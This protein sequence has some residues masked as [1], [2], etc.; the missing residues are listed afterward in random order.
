MMKKQEIKTRSRELFKISMPMVVEHLAIAAMGM[1]STMLVA[2]IGPHATTALGMVDSISN[3]IIAL[4]AALTTGGTI[5]VAQFIGKQ[6]ILSAKR[7]AGQAILLSVAFSVVVLAV[8]LVFHNQ[9]MYLLFGDADADV[10]AAALTFLFIVSFSFPVLAV[11]QT[12]FGIL[13]GSGDT[14]TPMII[15]ILMNAANLGL[16]I[17]LIHGLNLGIFTI[18]AFGVP[19]AA[20][21]LLIA[22]VMGLA[23]A[24]FFIVKK[25]RGVRLNKP[26]FFKPDMP[27]QKTILNLGMPTSFESALF[28]VGRLITQVF[29]VQIS[30]EAAETNTIA[31]SIANFVNVPG[32]ALATGVMI[33]VGQ[34]IGRGDVDDVRKTVGFATVMS[35]ILFAG[36]CLVMFFVQGP[37]FALFNPTDEAL[38]Y[39]PMVFASYLIATPL[40]W[41]ISFVIPA[42]LRAT[43]DVVFPMVVSIFTM[44]ILRVAFSYLFGILMGMGI[45]GIWLAMYL[46][47]AVRSAFFLPRLLGNKWKG[48]GIMAPK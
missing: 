24:L 34:R 35:S 37:I 46:D 20:M 42:A 32:M 23:A 38:S 6:D 45:M 21:A 8:L 4:F 7:A 17:V 10:M 44:L 26:R 11:T 14:L 9:L 1:I 2:S 40:I 15:S 47:W 12:I 39:L 25:A 18:P 22:R 33:L 28:H 43:G 16:G 27:I 29:I 13:R 48:K 30:M 36:L 5:V 3:L 41:S 31:G 19:G